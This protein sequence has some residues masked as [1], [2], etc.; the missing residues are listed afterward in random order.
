MKINKGI[1]MFLVRK[2]PLHL[3]VVSHYIPLISPMKRMDL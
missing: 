3:K 2:N 1:L